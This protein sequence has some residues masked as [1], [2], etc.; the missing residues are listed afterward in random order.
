MTMSGY[1]MTEKDIDQMISVLKTIDPNNATPEMAIEMLE[2]LHA[3][4][5]VMKH[6]NPEE[7]EKIYEELMKEKEGKESVRQD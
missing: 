1:K 6:E 5:H 3:T 2:H 4:V 7:L